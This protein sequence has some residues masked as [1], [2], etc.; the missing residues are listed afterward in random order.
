M[1]TV[2]EIE[3]AIDRLPAE[4][5]QQVREWLVVRTAPGGALSL[6]E[7]EAWLARLAA[8]RTQVATGKTAATSDAFWNDLRG[9]RS[10]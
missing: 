3:A 2:A 10:A 7:R 9:E 8:L 1:S 5:Q 4:E 6:G